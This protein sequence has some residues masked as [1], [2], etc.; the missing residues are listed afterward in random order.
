MKNFH[1]FTLI[2]LL[3][4]IAIIA[5]LAAMLLPA[6]NQARDRARTNNCLGN[7]K[8][9]GLAFAFYL[10]NYSDT[11][12]RVRY[13]DA[14][15]DTIYWPEVLIVGK[16]LEVKVLLDPAVAGW[17]G[18]EGENTI[19]AYKEGFSSSWQTGSRWRF[20][21][22]AYGYNVSLGNVNAGDP[23]IKSGRVKNPSA[24]LLLADTA[25]AD[26]LFSVNQFWGSY[27][28]P[29]VSGMILW[30]LHNGLSVCNTL[31]VDGHAAGIATSGRGEAGSQELYDAKLKGMFSPYD[32]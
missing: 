11:F 13:T 9:C 10:D 6:L 8:Q 2:E 5:I 19:K 7:I 25:R 21:N 17:G 20:N 27:S 31:Y 23:A 18:T 26:R 16:F 3:V 28:A 12:P 15:G 32:L 30:P 24:K 29:G 14:A 4:V 1:R 22:T